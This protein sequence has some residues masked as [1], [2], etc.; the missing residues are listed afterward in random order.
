[1]RTGWYSAMPVLIALV[2]SLTA[3]PRA[4]V[5][6]QDRDP[7]R[8]D[9]SGRWRLNGELSENAEAKLERM[10]SQSSGGHG[11]ARH[12]GL[13]GLFGGSQQSEMEEAG[14]LFLNAPQ[15][16]EVRQDGD[17]IA[18]SDSGGHVR[19]LNANGR[20]EKI[21]G[22]DVRTKW[23]KQRL[24]SEISVGSVKVT[25]TYERSTDSTQLIVTTKLDMHGREMSVR[26]VYE[27]ER[28]RGEPLPTVT[29]PK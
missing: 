16:F 19:T 5:V 10:Q 6:G 27:A 7:L 2:G 29:V 8:P 15:W 1:M 4:I 22:R 20:K 25:E 12:G 3:V 21:D 23:D 14:G 11:A 26:R 9:L 28:L 18:L 24:V 17:R 13:G